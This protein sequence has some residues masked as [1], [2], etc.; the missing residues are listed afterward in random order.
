MVLEPNTRGCVNENTKSQGV[1][2]E[3]PQWLKKGT[4]HCLWKS[5]LSRRVLKSVGF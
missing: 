5:V 2:C 1:D 4:K 3:I